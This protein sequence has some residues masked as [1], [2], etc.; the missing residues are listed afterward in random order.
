MPGCNGRNHLCGHCRDALSQRGG[1][2]ARSSAS[3]A[4]A[5]D[6][7]SWWLHARSSGSAAAKAAAAPKPPPSRPHC[8]SLGRVPA[9]VVRCVLLFYL[10]GDALCA[11]AA[12]SRGWR[13]PRSSPMEGTHWRALAAAAGWVGLATELGAAAA[14]W[15][16]FYAARFEAVSILR[17]PAAAIVASVPPAAAAEDKT[18]APA[19][20]L[21][22]QRAGSAPSPSVQ[23]ELSRR[24]GVQ[25]AA[26]A[27]LL[28]ARVGFAGAAAEAAAWVECGC[29][30]WAHVAGG[31]TGGSV[32]GGCD[33]A[34]G[35]VS[36][37]CTLEFALGGTPAEEADGADA[38]ARALLG[39]CVRLGGLSYDRIE[40]FEL[41]PHRQLW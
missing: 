38:A 17:A 39:L 7:W 9:E 28:V 14:S 24:A 5:S 12:T 2:A 29:A 21:L 16:E 18:L 35:T 32:G 37:C 27:Q 4:A 20:L 15:R 31:V 3:A 26:A 34:G 11:L 1:A 6:M 22:G 10:P 13:E 40:C 25:G 36:G 41:H 23:I 33:G 30:S 19:R 8:V